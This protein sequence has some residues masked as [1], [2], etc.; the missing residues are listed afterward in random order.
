MKRLA[1]LLSLLLLACSSGGGNQNDAGTDGGNTDEVFFDVS[2][3][4]QV[5]PEGL[6]MLTDAGLSTSVAGLRVRV[7]EPFKVA[8]NENDPLGIFSSALLD[9]N[10]SFSAS[11]ISTEL[12]NLGVAA[13]VRDDDDAGTR[14]VRSATGIW[15]V[16]FEGKKPDHNLTG[17]K[18]W[19]LP[20][21]LHDALTAAVTPAAISNIAPGKTTLISAGF[22]L[23]RIV[24]AQGKPVGDATVTPTMSNLSAQFFYPT[25]DFTGTGLKTSATG[26]FVYV[27][28]EDMVSTF[29]F[30]VTGQSTYK[31][32]QAGA[33]RGA[34]LVMTVFPG[35][36]PP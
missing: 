6:A 16:A 28:K 17:A 7:E 30:D 20:K 14:I 21:V 3:T 33:A 24:D 27:Q 18:A 35:S 9:S 8:L 34:A 31:Q 36:T 10:A 19:V 32:R 29:R 12:V 25:A 26:L 23:G 11:Q 5:F 4:A 15:D 1:L 2:G 22:M 13:G